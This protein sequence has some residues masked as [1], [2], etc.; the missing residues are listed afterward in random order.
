MHAEI[1]GPNAYRFPLTTDS[2]PNK[3]ITMSFD[4]GSPVSFLPMPILAQ[5]GNPS[6]QSLGGPAPT[7]STATPAATPGVEGTATTGTAQPLGPAGGTPQAPPGFGFLW[8]IVALF[9]FMIFMQWRTAKAD[10]RKREELLNA[11]GKGDLV[12]TIG[13]EIGTIADLRDNE[14]VLKFEEGKVRYAKSA[15]QVVLKSAKAKDSAIV[16]SKDAAPTAVSV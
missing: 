8:V 4:L 10:K 14:V 3:G 6:N 1:Q 7:S 2:Q 13:G 9:A 12:Q 16:E 5:A 15:V 11:L